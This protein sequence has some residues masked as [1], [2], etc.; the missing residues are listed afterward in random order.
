MENES[1]ENIVGNA[2]VTVGMFDGLHIGHR[3]I[4]QLLLEQSKVLK[5]SPVVV[6]FEIHP[7]VVL[8]NDIAEFRILTTLEER[9][10]LIRQMGIERVEVIHFTPAVAQ[11]SACQ[12]ARQYLIE[13]LHMGALLLGYDNMFGNKRNNDFE[14]ISSLASEAGFRIVRDDAVKVDNI[15]VSS[16]QI[17]KALLKGDIE[18][19]NLMLGT[20][21]SLTGEVVHG[22]QIGRTLGFPT[23]NIRLRD[24]DKALPSEGVYAAK[25]NI[26][27]DAENESKKV[28]HWAMANI[29][30]QPTFGGENS[31]IEVHLLDDRGN[32]Y[33]QTLQVSLVSRLRD[34]RKFDTPEALMTQLKINQL[35][36]ESYLNSN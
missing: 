19:A 9:L 30:P 1:V 23:A 4:L 15:E 33:G 29:G 35:Q 28:T 6:T 22:R 8:Q 12:F 25:V 14:H 34:I 5:M 31:T 18:R 27:S 10:D 36:V 13:K 32:L 2:I 21:Y 7:R 11:L 17:R 26:I 24:T 20:T 16:T 3:H